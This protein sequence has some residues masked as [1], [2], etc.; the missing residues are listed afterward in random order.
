MLQNSVNDKRHKLA[1]IQKF[2][3]NL[4]MYAGGAHENTESKGSFKITSI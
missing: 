3:I 2:P 4:M 1:T